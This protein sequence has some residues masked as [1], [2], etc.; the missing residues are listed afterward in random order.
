[1]IR[2]Q[3]YLD[4]ILVPI[5][6]EPEQLRAALDHSK[7]ILWVDFEGEPPEICEPILLEIFRFHPLAI[8]DALHQTHIP[9]VDEWER[10]LYIALNAVSF[11]SE[12]GDLDLNEIDI[13]LGENYLVTHHDFPIQA[14]DRVWQN[15]QKD[16]RHRK[17]GVDHILY[18]I[19]DELTVDFMRTVEDLDED[20]EEVEDQIFSRPNNE[21]VQRVF[22]LKRV[23]MHLR[24]SLSPMREVLNK[25]ARDNY[26]QID[27]RDR[28]YFR[29]VYD[30]LVRLHD[31]A[32]GLRDLV[33]GVLDTY[34][35][36]VNNRM[37]DIMRTLTLITTLFMP[38]SFVAG[39]FGMNFFQPVSAQLLSWTDLPAYLVT[40]VLIALTPLGMSFWMRR[41]GWMN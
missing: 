16:E 4:G 10:Y 41:K 12:S 23:T 25:L 2:T 21:L 13:F 11:T 29:D 37:N 28:I 1:M 3:Y 14:L 19:A 26:S 20:I 15:V 5:Q 40:L 35:S 39:F 30:H 32:E 7:G 17:A 8:E 22:N 34:L 36:V 24:R 31:I 33:G 27:V 6:P 9:K 18:L 38:I